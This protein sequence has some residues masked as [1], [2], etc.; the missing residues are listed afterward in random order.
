MISIKKT[1]HLYDYVIIFSNLKSFLNWFHII[2]KDIY[3]LKICI[4]SN[5]SFLDS[6]KLITLTYDEVVLAH[7]FL[8]IYYTRNRI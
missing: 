2:I 6:R 4:F 3:L 8:F 1:L 7:Y 5:S